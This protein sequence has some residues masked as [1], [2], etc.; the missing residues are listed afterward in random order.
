MRVKDRT[1]LAQL[2][3]GTKLDD[4]KLCSCFNMIRLTFTS[5]DQLYF[6]A[7][8][9]ATARDRSIALNS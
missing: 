1:T 6:A 5:W 8:R 9:A 2:V 3:A 7:R 4:C